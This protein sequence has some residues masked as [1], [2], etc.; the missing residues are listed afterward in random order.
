MA[1]DSAQATGGRHIQSSGTTR[2]QHG[3]A[4]GN[5]LQAPAQTAAWEPKDSSTTLGNAQG[6][7]LLLQATMDG[8]GRP[9]ASAKKC[10]QS[11]TQADQ[12]LQA[13]RIQVV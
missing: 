12:I 6:G 10:L 5:V 1:E 8:M 4:G 11:V 3:L 9:D 7:A 2:H 13:L